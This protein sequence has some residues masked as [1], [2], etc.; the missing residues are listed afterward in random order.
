VIY[1]EHKPIYHVYNALLGFVALIP[2]N[3]VLIPQW[4]AVGA[5][6]SVAAACLVSG[7]A[8]S[9]VFPRLRSTGIDQTLAFFA[10]RRRLVRAPA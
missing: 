2:L 10:I 7:V 6:L 3:F 8:S 5:A 9:W 1:I 4:G